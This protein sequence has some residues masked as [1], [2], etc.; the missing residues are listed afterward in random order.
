M[1]SAS[2]EIHHS[3]LFRVRCL[4]L[5]CILIAAGSASAADPG[6]L[7][8]TEKEQ[9]SLRV[10]ALPAVAPEVVP[11]RYASA[12]AGPNSAQAN[13]RAESAGAF[14]LVGLSVGMASG[15][16]LFFLHLK[17]R[18][19]RFARHDAADYLFDD[20]P[21]RPGF[22]ERSSSRRLPGAHGSEVGTGD[23]YGR[24]KKSD[25]DSDNADEMIEQRE[26][27]ERSVDWWKGDSNE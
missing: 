20:W 26:P 12:S 4:G 5:A 23:F 3:P 27:W 13:Q 24:G 9:A 16:G 14:F 15:I 8:A 18:E 1:M 21:V 17:R 2:Q 11:D 19:T 10:S 25:T 7:N 22:G 6:N